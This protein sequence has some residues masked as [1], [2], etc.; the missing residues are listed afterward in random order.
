M[1]KSFCKKCGSKKM[2]IEI[3]PDDHAQ[4]IRL[5]CAECQAWIKWCSFEQAR[6]LWDKKLS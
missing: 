4:P 3:L 6:A 5:T 2:T 1:N